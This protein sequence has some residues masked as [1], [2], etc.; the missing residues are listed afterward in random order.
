MKITHLS[1]VYKTKYESVSALENIHLT[2][3]DRGLV[4]IVGVSGSGKTTLMN[5]L[6]GVDKPTTGDVII[7]E[8][9][10]YNTEEKQMFGYRNSY[11]GLVFQDYNLI[12]DLNVYDNIKLPFE[13]LGKTDFS[14]VDEVIK[15]VD[16]ED[17]KYSKV[18]EISSGQMQRVA[19]ARALI[20]DSSLILADEPTGNLDSKNER[21]ILDLLKEISKDRLVVVIT[22]GAEA[23]VEYGDRIIEIEDGNIVSDT[24]PITEVQEQ[25]PKFV[26]PKTKFKQQVKFTK[27][28]I[29]NNLARSL[30]IA[31]LLLL[32]PIIGGILSGYVFYDVS[33]AFKMH[34]DEYKSEYVTLSQSLRG[35][36]LYYTSEQMEEFQ[37][38]YPGSRL[39]EHTDANFNINIHNLP[40]DYFYR[41]EI[42]NILIYDSKFELEGF[43]PIDETEIAITDYLLESLNYYGITNTDTLTLDGN[44][45]K[46]VGIVKTN[47]QDFKN[48]NFSQDEYS[49][50]AFE[51]NLTVYNA[52]F[53]SYLSR[54]YMINHMNS[55][56]ETISTTVYAGK[57]DPKKSYHEITI[58][59]ANKAKTLVHGKWDNNKGYGVISQALF[60]E[61]DLTYEDID[62]GKRYVF[63]SF[64]K[65]KYNIAI[66]ITGVYDSDEPGV[67]MN[68]TDFNTYVNKH[69][70]SR[71]LIFKDDKNYKEILNNE[72]VTNLSFVNAKNMWTKAKDSKIV[73]IEFLIVLLTIV[74]A[75]ASIVNSMTINSEKKKI[76]IKYSFGMKKLT[77]IVPYVLEQIFYIIFSF[78]ISTM[79]VKYVFPWFMQAIIYT[80][81]ADIKAFDFFYIGWQ[82]VI[83]WNF[84]IYAI[85]L[86][87]LMV[88]IYKICR[89]S[90]IEIIKDL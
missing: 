88:M 57:Q 75:F 16:I 56:K 77:I 32:V 55:Y 9:S 60:D 64:S 63:Y 80:K 42:N 83:G 61:M 47:Y 71:I 34:Q 49:R 89:K 27:G 51:E 5:I 28:F 84:V 43:E 17:I 79:V 40:E 76:G 58:Y 74:I 73:M 23:A 38:K 2:L 13:L 70:R 54:V 68:S 52:I 53:A 90:P 82:T 62:L 11:V 35:F 41:P 50:L 25:T 7:G 20:K 59:N 18:T 72:N 6:S 87:S 67:I 44:T 33:T 37:S 30:A 86:V 65:T 85:M 22:H 12:E 48:I 31:L 1:K 46:V 45:Y 4:F 81:E 69:D 66:R 19:I 3:P 24:N 78:I 29:R 21:I 14:K 8:R 36:D 10:L 39:I 15:K 26:E